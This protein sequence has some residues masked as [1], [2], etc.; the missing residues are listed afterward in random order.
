MNREIKL[1]TLILVL[2]SFGI[3]VGYTLKDVKTYEAV[4]ISSLVLKIDK[5]ESELEQ[6]KINS[7]EWEQQYNEDW[8][9]INEYVYSLN[10]EDMDKWYSFWKQHE[11]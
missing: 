8:T 7:K 4:D 5:L 10:K 3:F 1:I 11:K 6:E 2:I 9:T